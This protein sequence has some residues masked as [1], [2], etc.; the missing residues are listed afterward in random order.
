MKP[1]VIDDQFPTGK[2]NTPILITSSKIVI[3]TLFLLT[4]ISLYYIHNTSPSLFLSLNIISNGTSSIPLHRKTNASLHLR[5]HAGATDTS[6]TSTSTRT[7]QSPEIVDDDSTPQYQKNSSTNGS[8][9]RTNYRSPEIVI[10]GLTNVH[11]RNNSF[12]SLYSSNIASNDSASVGLD[13]VCNIFKGEWVPNPT[14][15]Y[16]TNETKSCEIDDRQNCMKFGRPDTEYMKWRWK[17]YKCELPLFDAVAFL[18]L[19][20]GKNLAFLGDSVGR[21]QMQSLVCLLASA[22]IPQ[23]VSNTPDKRFRRWL[24]ADYNFTIIALWSPLLVKARE[25]DEPQGYLMNLYLD[26]PDE[27]WTSQMEN[28]DILIISAGQ[29]F[30]RPFVYYQKGKIVGCHICNKNNIK[31]LDLFYTYKMAFRTAFQTV[32]KARKFKALT[33]LRTFSASQFEN[34]EWNTGGDCRRKKPFTRQEMRLDWYNLELYKTQ[35]KELKVA[36]RRGEKRGLKFRVLDTTEAMLMRPDGHPSHYGHWPH[37][38]KTAADCVHWCMPGPVDT[39]NEFLFQMLKMEREE[40]SSE[41]KMLGLNQ[42][43][44]QSVDGF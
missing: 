10:N 12:S 15:P 38:N 14:G 31:E 36:E 23:D 7:N 37:D 5:S 9:T 8:S 26:E 3:L 2:N 39:W 24:Y 20:R 22:A 25:P 19:V 40:R 30:F 33:F 1:Q 29:W 17:P 42:E 27:A 4:T 28:I 35:V 13:R 34:G 6:T 44:I 43:R 41:R 18:E 16:Y 11:Q 21:N 32:L